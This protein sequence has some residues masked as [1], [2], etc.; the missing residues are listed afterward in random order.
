VGGC[1]VGNGYV[2]LARSIEVTPYLSALRYILFIKFRPI[3]YVKRRLKESLRRHCFTH[4][5]AIFYIKLNF[6]F[7]FLDPPN[8]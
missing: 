5:I 2:G 6:C 3:I 8:I 1:C 4:A 7:C